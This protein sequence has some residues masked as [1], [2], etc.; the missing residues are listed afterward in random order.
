VSSRA[1]NFVVGHS[2]PYVHRFVDAI[3]DPY[4]ATNPNGKLV[5]AV[6][7]NK[8]AHDKLSERLN[9]FPG[10]TS[11]V[12]NYTMASGS[13][14]LKSS[15][16]RF[17][18]EF[19]FRGCD[20]RPENL[21]VAPGCCALLH[22]LAYLLFEPGDCILVPT[23]FYPA[24]DHDF[25]NLGRVSVVE[26][27]CS[28]DGVPN[29]ELTASGLDEAFARADNKAKALLLTNPSNPLGTVYTR[30]QLELAIEWTRARGL[31]LICDEIYALSC[32]SHLDTVNGA[33]DEASEYPWESV[34]C[35]LA[36][37]G[38]GLGE[39]V[40]VMWSLSK[41]FGASGFRVGCL[42]T[43][44]TTLLRALGSFADMEQ[45]SMLAQ[46]ITAF[47][48]ND[49]TWVSS[50][51][52]LVRSRTRACYGVLKAGL[53][54]LPIPL[55]VIEAQAGIF[56]FV[57]ARP[58][59]SRFSQA[60]KN[61]RADRMVEYDNESDDGWIVEEALAAALYERSGLVVTPGRSCHCKVPG[62][63]RMCYAWPG[64]IEAVEEV[65]KRL[66]NF[67]IEL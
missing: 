14:A 66:N 1:D 6:A 4:T 32:F 11:A 19:M 65:L 5:M 37:Q 23:P 53:A 58:M 39:H 24:F 16:V 46:E 63:F 18:S 41:D 3:K 49:H 62:F 8:L 9:S 34:A 28:D 25:L 44:N 20:V 22:A 26:V 10:F 30:A 7:E 42:Y 27:N 51:L 55:A 56:V 31:H 57:D 59:F 40:H 52:Q 61:K 17:L 43:Q 60:E 48:L 21:I 50:F 15:L 54:A 45:V 12:F 2:L 36:R 35:V 29:F 33:E 64:T 13:P 67:Q 38:Q 47:L